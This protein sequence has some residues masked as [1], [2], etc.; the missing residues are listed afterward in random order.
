MEENIKK[1]DS[2]KSFVFFPPVYIE[3]GEGISRKSAN[4]MNNA[5]TRY[6]IFGELPD[7]TEWRQWERKHFQSAQRQIDVS[8]ERYRRAKMGGDY[9]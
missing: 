5:I 4:R 6:G 1:G 2:H 3:A 8:K 7:T 9:D